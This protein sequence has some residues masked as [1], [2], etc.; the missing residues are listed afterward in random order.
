MLSC[1]IIGH[2]CCSA[3][4]VRLLQEF[5]QILGELGVTMIHQGEGELFEIKKY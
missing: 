2:H 1:L 4:L 3:G 5:E